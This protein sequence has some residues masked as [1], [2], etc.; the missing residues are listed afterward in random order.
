MFQNGA[1]TIIQA[2]VRGILARHQA[3]RRLGDIYDK[4]CQR[5]LRIQLPS[6]SNS[7]SAH[8][9]DKHTLVVPYKSKHSKPKPAWEQAFEIGI[10]TGMA[11]ALLAL[12]K[13][14]RSIIIRSDGRI[15]QTRSTSKAQ[16]CCKAMPPKKPSTLEWTRTG[17]GYSWP[18]RECVLLSWRNLQ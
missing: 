10:T 5:L 4:Q 15:V 2:R 17:T 1:A 6:E 14:S 3:S 13:R 12:C 8:Q 9:V 7:R 16:C 11:Y 18:S